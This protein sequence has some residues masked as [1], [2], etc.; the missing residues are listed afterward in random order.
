MRYFA[1]M[2]VNNGTRLQKDLEGNNKNKLAKCI[3]SSARD[4]CFLNNE[5]IWLVWDEDGVIVSAG[6]GRST[7][8]GYAYYSMR[9]QIGENI[10]Y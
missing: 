5:F 10:N 1:N 8:N 7:N 6:A 4:E 2:W 3:S 9:H